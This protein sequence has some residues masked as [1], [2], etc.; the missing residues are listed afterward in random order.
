MF[1]G[2]ARI[3]RLA[4]GHWLFV[5]AVSMGFTLAY[6][7]LQLGLMIVKFE[8][9]P[10][11][12]NVYDWPTN[13]MRI[14]DSTPSLRDT[15]LIIKEEWL[16]EVGFMNYEYGIGISQWSLY[17]SPVKVLSIMVLGVMLAL[18]SLL[19]RFSVKGM[20]RTPCV[21]VAGVG[22]TAA[23]IS[24]MSLSWVVCCAT[25]SWVVGLSIL[26]LGVS[27]AL[28]LAPIGIWLNMLGFATLAVMIWLLAIKP[29]EGKSDNLNDRQPAG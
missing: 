6:Y 23:S 18:L 3:T 24:L 5:L 20:A 25:P 9:W 19:A 16:V 12:A 2:I 4:V 28:W 8:Q 13:V 11:Y 21:I 17:L 10:N 26:G 22:A 1:K 15:V 14:I 27:T 29:G 7:T